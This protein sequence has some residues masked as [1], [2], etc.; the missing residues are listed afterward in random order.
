MRSN[1]YFKN[2]LPVTTEKKGAGYYRYGYN[3]SLPI[4]LVDIIN[5]S[6]VALKALNKQRDYMFAD[7]FSDAAL[8]QMMANDEQNF[9]E[10]LFD[11][12]DA[13][14]YFSSSYL[15]L[16]RNN[17]GVVV[18]ARMIPNMNVR[19]RLD[20]DYM[21]NPTIGTLK[22]EKSGWVTIPKY[23]GKVVLGE[24]LSKIGE[25]GEIYEIS[26]KSKIASKSYALP[27]Y[28]SGIE[29]VRSSSEFQKMILEGSLNGMQLGGMVSFFGVSDVKDEKGV[30]DQDVI[31]DAMT[32]F[33][34]LNKNKDGLTSRFGV[35]VNFFDQLEQKPQFDKF[36]TKD[37]SEAINKTREI[38]DRIVARLFD[39]HPVLIGF[40]ATAILGNDN[41]MAQASDLLK[42]SVLGKQNM[43]TQDLKKIFWHIPSDFKISSFGGGKINIQQ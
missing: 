3:D 7:G 16:S 33:T 13:T 39:V 14:A 6:G 19:L 43:I 27:D 20:G 32:Q 23:K 42:N 2:M 29:D 18:Q 9:D 28:L 1:V 25:Y 22:E 41:A 40:D 8:S 38:I 36:D 17:A 10:L 34:G 26:R 5:S 24:E 30:S 35:L 31:N 11:V 12:C 21:Y 15:Q 37:T 4:E